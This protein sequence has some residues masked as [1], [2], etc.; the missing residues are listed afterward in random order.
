M[1]ENVDYTRAQR[2]L[3]KRA[4]TD[5]VVMALAAAQLGSNYQFDDPELTWIW[6]V[7]KKCFDET[8][9]PPSWDFLKHAIAGLPDASQDATREQLL[10]VY[11]ATAEARPRA[12][13]QMLRAR[14]KKA[15]LVEG[16]ERASERWAKGDDDGAAAILEQAVTGSE[17][18]PGPSA[19][20][21]FPRKFNPAK[22][23]PRIPTGL[24][25]LDEKIGGIQRKEVGM[26]MGVS[27]MGKSALTVTLGHA[28]IRHGYRVLHIDTENGENITLA[29][30]LSRFT[31][32]PAKLI[33]SNQLSREQRQRLDTWMERNFERLQDRFRVIYLN[34]MENTVKD[35]EAAV[36]AEIRGG[37]RPDEIIFDSPDHLLME[38]GQA[39][40][41][42]FA[43]VWNHLKGMNQR[44]DTAMWATSQ[45]DMAFEGKIATMAATADS[46]QKPRVASLVL[47]INQLLDPMGKPI[48]DRKCVY[49]AKARNDPARFALPLQTHLETMKISCNP[50]GDDLEGR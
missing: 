41:E 20:P 31:G 21:M 43:Y 46:K 33:E 50:E 29:R 32:I 45:A 38:Q 28:G 14:A 40:W 12:T 18:R 22:T 44:L 24:R 16:A 42:Q 15:A 34:Y 3:L 1:N 49:L 7:G 25:L 2:G 39:R 17:A 37:F 19:K 47:T 35:L 36:A 13:M 4:F 6:Q 26:V 8:G 10:S 11:R 27:G 48:D 30:Y 9:E 23:P 5:D